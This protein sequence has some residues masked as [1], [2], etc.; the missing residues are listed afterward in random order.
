V[1]DRTKEYIPSFNPFISFSV[2]LLLFF[3]GVDRLFPLFDLPPVICP[4]GPV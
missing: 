3:F 1:I 2:L 4:G